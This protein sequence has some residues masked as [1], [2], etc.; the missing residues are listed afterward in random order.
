MCWLVPGTLAAQELVPLW[1][2]GK[3]PNSRGL[4]LA[5]SIANERLYVV[6]T[7]KLR[8]FFP[9]SAET[10]GAAVLICPG[11]GYVRTAYVT[12]GLQL[13]KWFNTLGVSA[14]VLDYRLP[15]SPDVLQ[16][17]IAPLQDAQ[18][19]MRLLRAHAAEWNIS[20]SRIGVMGISA[21]G[22]LATTLGTREE[23]VAAIGDSVDKLPYKPNFMILV[24]PVITMGELTHVGS[25]TALLGDHPSAEL[26]AKYSN[27]LH[28][29]AS[30][31]PAF[32]VHAFD[33]KAVPVQNSL[34][35]YEALVAKH[36]SST[37]HVFPRGG[38]SIALRNNPGSTQLWTR[39]CEEW[40][41][42]MGF[43]TP[44]DEKREGN[45]KS[46]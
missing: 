34:M 12:S 23:D 41:L 26:I 1:P 36:D 2:P 46:R 22:H 8:A 9:S 14:F 27:E 3:M 32:I 7:P 38:H 20:P 10:S 39:L 24:S 31:P 19:A 40:M 11:G 17:E 43:L 29:T 18:R 35:F 25:R 30:T 21:G 4:S 44:P 37:L 45:A 6:G 15:N 28:V 16:R 5:D 33:D 13:A 42:E